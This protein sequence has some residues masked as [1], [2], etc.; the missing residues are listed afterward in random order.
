MGFLLGGFKFDSCLKQGFYLCFCRLSGTRSFTLCLGISKSE[1][2]AE[3]AQALFNDSFSLRFSTI[4]IGSYCMEDTIEAAMQVR[5]TKRTNLPPT[6]RSL[7][8]QTF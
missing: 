5:S 1:E 4:V 2:I 3:I 7:D 8:F 6:H